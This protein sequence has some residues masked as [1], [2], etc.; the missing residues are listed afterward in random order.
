MTLVKRRNNDD[1]VKMNLGRVSG[2]GLNVLE[3]SRSRLSLVL[4]SL[5]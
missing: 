2:A 1:G 3:V 4:R 5:E